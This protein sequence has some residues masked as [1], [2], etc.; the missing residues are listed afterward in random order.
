M[1]SWGITMRQND[2][3]LD[4]LGTIVD[5]QLKTVDFLTF[6]VAGALEVIQA[7][8]IEEIRRDNCGS[9]ADDFVF[10]FSE[11]FPQIFTQGTLLVAECLA[12]YDHK[13][14]LSYDYVGEN[15]APVEHRNK[16]FVTMEAEQRVYIYFTQEETM[17][18]MSCGKDKAPRP[19]RELDQNGIGLIQH[20]S[21]SGAQKKLRLL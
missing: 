4:L 21:G 11:S 18:L 17:T 2:Y 9:N 19:F 5:T 20:K 8:I 14:S 16:E 3:G 12:H 13:G 10:Y 6:I 1:G 7:D 15:Y